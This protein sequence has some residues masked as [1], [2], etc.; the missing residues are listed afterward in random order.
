MHL[1]VNVSVPSHHI[2]DV[3]DDSEKEFLC[4]S[5][6]IIILS[7]LKNDH[8]KNA[9]HALGQCYRRQH[10]EDASDSLIADTTWTSALSEIT[11]HPKFLDIVSGGD[12]ALKEILQRMKKGE[13]HLQW[14]PALKRISGDDPVP[15]EAR[16]KIPLMTEAWLRWGEQK[17]FLGS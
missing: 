1:H 12:V 17:G 9:F 7:R 13:T 4:R 3:D 5:I 15:P 2:I 14:F 8:L 16:G 10:F 11:T 6:S